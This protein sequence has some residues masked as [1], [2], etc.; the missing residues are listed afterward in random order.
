MAG[1]TALAPGYVRFTYDGVLFPHHGTIPVNYDGTPTPGSEP[2]ILL[3]DGSSLGVE[4]ALDAY[5]D[6]LTPHFNTSVNFGNAEAHAVDSVTGEDTFLWTWN[7]AR[8]GSDSGPAIATGQA[9]FSFK[10]SVG[11]QLK[12]YL[13]ESG[14]PANNKFLPPY[15]PGIIADLSDYVASA[16][17]MFYGRGN[18]YALAPISFITK[19]NDK[20]RK[21]QGLA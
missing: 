7:A 4:A 12:V 18:A 13:M 6:V 14:S 20:L 11:S 15:A 8:V 5:L 10:T 9:V 17:S 3:K 1:D 19:Y 2:D 16:A 21:Q